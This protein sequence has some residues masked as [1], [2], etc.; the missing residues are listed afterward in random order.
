M[1]TLVHDNTQLP[2]IDLL[3][4]LLAPGRHHKLGYQKK[5]SLFL[6]KPYTQC[7]DRVNI[8]MRAVF[9]GYREAD[10]GFSQLP[11]FWACTQAYM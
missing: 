1:V 6:A 2:N 11:C 5:T 10:Y 7:N 3:A 8:G 9:E 4:T